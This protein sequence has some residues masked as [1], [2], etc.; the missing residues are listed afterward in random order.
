MSENPKPE[1]QEVVSV[2]LDEELKDADIDVLLSENDPQFLS[3]MTE[4]GNEKALS[5]TQEIQITEKD[6]FIAKLKFRIQLA[7]VVWKT[8]LISIALFLFL[9]LPKK[10]F[11]AL[12]AFIGKQVENLSEAQR[13]FRYLSWK[14]KLGFFGIV[15]LFG[16]TGFLIYRTW[17]Q[18]LVPENY[19]L[20]IRS[21]EPLANSSSEYDPETETEAF[22]QN[23]R[24]ANNIL[25]LPK[26]V[27][28]IKKSSQSGPNP[29]A[30]FEFYL[31]GVIPEVV[32]EIKDRE[33]E[34]RDLMQR[35]IEEFT[36]DQ[37]D[38]VNGKQELQE[39]L[40]KE[41][42]PLLTTGKLK[43]VLIKTV[44]LKP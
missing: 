42:N 7:I 10:T 2:A 18:G 6:S 26:M 22:Y 44:I 13:S 31:E 14:M 5:Q 30:A 24:T 4:I 3:Q 27:V 28:N 34:I 21:L 41:I 17:S 39:K 33:S 36:F 12:K 19:D 29:M 40:Q 9:K 32:I 35:S 8:R 1:N 25:L 23:L 43:N 16:L 15:L 37:L 11:I 38:T 20:F